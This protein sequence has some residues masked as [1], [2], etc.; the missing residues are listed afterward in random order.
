MNILM[1]PPSLS[2]GIAAIP[3]RGQSKRLTDVDGVVGG[4]RDH[5]ERLAWPSSSSPSMGTKRLADCIR[6]PAVRAGTP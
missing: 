5:T 6:A 2:H 3:R 4:R 1:L